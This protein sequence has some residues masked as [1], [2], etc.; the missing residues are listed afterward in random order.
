MNNIA[1][2]PCRKNSKEVKNKN[3]KIF[4]KKPLLYWTIK[5]ARSSSLI[6]KVF[7]TSDSKK[8]LKYAQ[9]YG[10]IP[11]KRPKKLA[12]DNSTSEDALL[13]AIK[14]INLNFK[15]VI[16][17]QATSPL[18]KKNDITNAIRLFEKG[19]YDSLFSSSL[20][21]SLFLW[22]YINKNM[23]IIENSKEIRKPRQKVKNKYLENGSLYIFK[24]KGFLKHK[25]RFFGK[26]GTYV[27]DKNYSYEIDSKDE[28]KLLEFI[29][30]NLIKNEKKK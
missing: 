24:K 18:R 14:K 10:A 9:K 26:I 22:K 12:N 19:K 7:V 25:N 1:I 23:K 6:S 11:I 16:F 4:N 20:A 17:L 3:I 5:S 29:S 2:I 30:N 8:I 13:H 27:M 15:N 21:S 28:F